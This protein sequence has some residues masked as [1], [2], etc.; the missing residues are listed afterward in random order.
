MDEAKNLVPECPVCGL[1]ADQLP[2]MSRFINSGD[3]SLVCAHFFGVPA[4]NV[5]D[6]RTYDPFGNPYSK[7]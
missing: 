4:S 3:G 6:W 2:P 5:P 7:E 1:K